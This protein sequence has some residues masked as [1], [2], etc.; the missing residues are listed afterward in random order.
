MSQRSRAR[1]ALPWVFALVAVL[2]VVVVRNVFEGSASVRRCDELRAQGDV[3][4]AIAQALHAARCYV[5]LAPH[6]RA[7]YDRLRDIALSAELSGDGETALLSWQAIHAG[8]RSTRSLWTPFSDR[9]AEADDHIAA[10]L[11]GRPPPGIDRDQ[12]RDVIAREHRALLAIGTATHPLAALGLYLGLAAWLYGAW[13]ALGVIGATGSS[14]RGERVWTGGALAI[15]G[16]V[17]MLIA[18]ARA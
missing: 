9:L 10:I 7:A 8:A 6:P 2:S 16:M 12:P 1:R 17:A 15:V 14:A 18:L 11:A 5:P 4:G 3:D 13:R